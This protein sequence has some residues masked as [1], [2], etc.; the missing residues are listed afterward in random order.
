MRGN[1]TVMRA[2]AVQT[3]L[4]KATDQE[5]IYQLYNEVAATPGGLARLQDEIHQDYV[6]SFLRRS[7]ENG[8]ALVAETD[9]GNIAGELHASSPGIYCFSHVL[10]DLTVA[11]SPVHQKQG[12]ARALFEKF[13][14]EL[15]K[16][17]PH[18][19]RVELIARESN[20]HALAFYQSL[21]FVKE[22][23][24]EGRIKNPDGSL[25]ADIPMAWQRSRT[26]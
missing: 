15:E 20:A 6:S 24:L 18:I 22:G 7:L 19:S 12:I 9:K 4:A 11:V 8:V 5:S 16:A 26:S 14:A 17:M 1:E 3:R 23:R 13:F 10:T 25:E 2:R 21:G